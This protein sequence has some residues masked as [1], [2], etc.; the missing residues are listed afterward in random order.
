MLLVLL[1]VR[2][3]IGDAPG[4]GAASAR[5]CYCTAGA[6][7]D[8]V[9]ML[10]HAPAVCCCSCMLLLLRL[11]IFSYCRAQ[12]DQAICTDNKT[13]CLAAPLRF[14]MRSVMAVSQKIWVNTLPMQYVCE[15]LAERQFC[16]ISAMF[17]VRPN[18]MHLITP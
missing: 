10:L 11:L 5:V 14:L 4:A 2:A 8:G 6:A 3:R 12:S 13:T 1:L 15:V 18:F 9:K 7:G 16:T 17:D